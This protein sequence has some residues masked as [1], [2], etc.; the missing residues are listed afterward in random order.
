M[1]EFRFR[2]TGPPKADRPRKRLRHPRRNAVMIGLGFLL[3]WLLMRPPPPEEEPP[4]VA[5]R[6]SFQ[7]TNTGTRSLTS[8]EVDVRLADGPCQAY[9][10]IQSEIGGGGG[11]G[12]LAPGESWHYTCTFDAGNLEEETAAPV[13]EIALE[14]SETD[15]R[16]CPDPGFTLVK[17]P[18]SASASHGAGVGLVY[19]LRSSGAGPYGDVSIEDDDCD[20]ETLTG[21]GP[22]DANSDNRLDPDE[23]WRFECSYSVP[24]GHRGEEDNPLYLRPA[25]AQG[26]DARG[27]AIAATSNRPPLEIE[28]LLRVQK[29][30]PLWVG[31]DDSFRPV[32]RVTNLRTD[33]LSYDEIEIEDDRCRAEPVA[34]AGGDGPLERGET[35]EYRCR[36][37]IQL[38]GETGDEVALSR[39]TVTARL[40]GGG[41]PNTAQSGSPLLRLRDPEYVGFEALPPGCFACGQGSPALRVPV[42]D[43]DGHLLVTASNPEFEGFNAAVIYNSRRGQAAPEPPAPECPPCRT[44]SERDYCSGLNYERDTDLSTP[45]EANDDHL[46]NVLIVGE[47]LCDRSPQDGLVDRPNDEGETEVGITLDLS[48]ILSAPHV[49]SLRFLG[50]TIVDTDRGRPWLVIETDGGRSSARCE[51]PRTGDNRVE[52]VRFGGGERCQLTGSGIALA[53]ARLETFRGGRLEDDLQG[54]RGVPG[55]ERVRIEGWRSGA[56]DDLAFIRETTDLVCFPGSTDDN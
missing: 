47:E 33:G 28:H 30:V 50:M 26:R 20:L 40:S 4:P 41:E 31:R 51:L 6:T 43:G 13:L 7:V 15:C 35:R 42:D 11:S 14:V 38:L 32:Y 1:T 9:T 48:P 49:S 16:A 3:A 8:E 5:L 22:S 56:I 34:P 36:D 25:S 37:P 54:A 12:L 23:A 17:L 10:A 53:D 45:G 18:A 27:R 19:W 52:R 21:P 46:G 55:V 24:Q 39:A 29:C 2:A 44:D